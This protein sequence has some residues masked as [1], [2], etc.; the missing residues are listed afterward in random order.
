LAEPSYE[1]WLVASAETL[2]LEGMRH[3]DPSPMGAIRRALPGAYIKPTWQPRLTAR[4]D[5]QLARTR[6]RSLNRLLRRF[7]EL[8]EL[9]R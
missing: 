6:S 2:E 7:N 9:V 8:C 3:D 1:A 5:I 4:M